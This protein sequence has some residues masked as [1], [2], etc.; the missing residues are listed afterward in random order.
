M[1]TQIVKFA[2]PN[3]GFSAAQMLQSGRNF[4][5]RQPQKPYDVNKDISVLLKNNYPD[6]YLKQV[7]LGNIPEIKTRTKH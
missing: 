7:K 2:N 1:K 4:V 5:V 3:D 6:E